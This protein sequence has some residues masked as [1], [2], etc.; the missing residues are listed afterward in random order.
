[1]PKRIG[2]EPYHVEPMTPAVP[3]RKADRN[4]PRPSSPPAGESDAGDATS[5][6]EV[7]PDELSDDPK[8]EISIRR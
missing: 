6:P 7:S 2:R 4:D 8:H 1:M 5:E 3:L